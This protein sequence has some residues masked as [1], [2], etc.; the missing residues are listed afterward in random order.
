MIG[1]SVAAQRRHE[2]RVGAP[3]GTYPSHA[4]DPPVDTERFDPVPAATAVSVGTSPA[5]AA[6]RR[7]V[8][9]VLGGLTVIFFLLG[10]IP[11]ARI[12]WDLALLTLGCTAAYVALLIH[13]HRLAVERAQKV[14]ALETRRHV[15]AELES[16]RHV[17]VDRTHVAVSGGYASGY[18]SL[19][20][21]DGG[22]S[23]ARAVGPALS[24]SGWSVTGVHSSR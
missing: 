7:Q 1:F 18:S 9:T 19:G 24:G 4:S 3:G 13:F 6:R 23:Y 20:Y 12:L 22:T 2:G 15:T 16:R 8:F 17:I 14:I 10:I 5:T 11:S 21:A